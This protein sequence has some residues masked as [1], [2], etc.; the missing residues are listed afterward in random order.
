MEAVGTIAS[1]VAHNFRNT[2]A[3]ILMNSQ[4]IQ[5]TY[6]RD[7]ALMEITERINASVKRGA[8]LVEGLMQ[9]SRKQM[10]KAFE[11]VD[12]VRVTEE[13]YQ[14][15][16][17]SF[18]QRIDIVLNLPPALFVM[19]DHSELNLAMLNLCTN[20]RDAMPGG[21]SL[22]ISAKMTD[23]M[24]ELLVADTGEGM[25]AGTLKNCFDPFFTTKEVGQ[26]TGLGLSTTYGIVKNHGG[27]ITA[28]SSPGQGTV[29]TVK[30]PLAPPAPEV[31]A[32]A[33]SETPKGNGEKVLVV[34][35]DREFLAAVP[36]LLEALG[37]RATVAES[38][39]DALE[40]Y[41]NWRPD[42]VLMD[43]NMPAVDGLACAEQI[44]EI[45]PAARI[46]IISGYAEDGPDGLEAH[47]RD[48]ICGYLTKPVDMVELGRMLHRILSAPRD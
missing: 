33:P 11:R 40:R 18:D 47:H 31:K 3:G 19:G 30:I 2:L 37:Y 41:R 1:G 45:D 48:H 26:G 24:A 34:D 8:E 39:R 17:K 12:L 28:R 46:A 21:G 27:R 15:I 13:I 23:G 9:F 22:T 38:P 10:R 7:N 20:A 36:P 32:A 5:L 16:R 6:P 4:V 44:I 14:I 42:A 25:N 43:R 35:D 29:F